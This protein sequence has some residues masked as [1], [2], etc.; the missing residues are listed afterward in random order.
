MKAIM[1]TG[2]L[3]EL[4]LALQ[5]AGVTLYGEKLVNES[6]LLQIECTP[7][8]NR[9]ILSS[10][11]ELHADNEFP[12]DSGATVAYSLPTDAE[13]TIINEVLASIDVDVD[14]SALVDVGDYDYIQATGETL[15][16]D[17]QPTKIADISDKEAVRMCSKDGSIVIVENSSVDTAN[18]SNYLGSTHT[19]SISSAVSE[20]NL[21]SIDANLVNDN[22]PGN[23][24]FMSQVKI[25]PMSEDADYVANGITNPHVVSSSPVDAAD[26]VLERLNS[27][28]G[29][30]AEDDPSSGAAWDIGI[31]H[32]SCDQS[33]LEGKKAVETGDLKEDNK[34]D[35]DNGDH[36]MVDSADRL[37]SPMRIAKKR[38]SEQAHAAPKRD[39][40]KQCKIQIFSISFQILS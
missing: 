27:H 40:K 2:G 19:N 17:C 12:S 16:Q 11:L 7:I 34:G 35:L 1:K 39:R 32:L 10:E 14:K 24:K 37:S 30:I 6:F 38:H 8:E 29:L 5:A 22:P 26:D 13:P 3:D 33:M 20:I 15:V 18:T 25:S 9:E 31:R 21:S 4:I 36:S 28:D 23:I